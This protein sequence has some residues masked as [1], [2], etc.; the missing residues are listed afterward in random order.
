MGGALE[1]LF[2]MT[3]RKS[4]FPFLYSGSLVTRGTKTPW[5]GLWRME[6]D[7]DTLIADTIDGQ[8]GLFRAHGSSYQWLTEFAD[9]S[10]A[11]DKSFRHFYDCIQNGNEPWPS[12]ADNLQTLGMVLNFIAGETK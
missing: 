11:F 7:R 3:S 8:Y 9:E 12:G 10:M 2:T 1:A 5:G 4:T 6:F